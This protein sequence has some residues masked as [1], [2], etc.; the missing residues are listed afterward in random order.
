MGTR[1]TLRFTALLSAAALML[2]ACSSPLSNN[3]PGFM[4]S[5]AAVQRS[6]G[7]RPKIFGAYVKVAFH[8]DF[9]ERERVKLF[10]SYPI[11]P[12]WYFYK[13][14][15]VEGRSKWEPSIP[16]SYPDGEV[17]IAVV[18]DRCRDVIGATHGSLDFKG[19][20]Y[21]NGDPQEATI[22]SRIE[23]FNF[24]LKFCGHQ[25]HPIERRPRC[26]YIPEPPGR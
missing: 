23:P 11:L 8:N 6:G 5:S 26:T 25:S 20:Q 3:A 15:C 1:S 21:S 14:Q 12:G 9:R 4:P 24:E 19:I 13:E 10:Y 2:A 22:T 17:R 16:F 18:Y 7:V